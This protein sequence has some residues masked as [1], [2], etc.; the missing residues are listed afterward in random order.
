MAVGRK[1]TLGRQGGGDD[2]IRRVISRVTYIRR[3][4][5]GSDG[6]RRAAGGGVGVEEAVSAGSQVIVTKGGEVGDGSTD[7]IRKAL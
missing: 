6:E 7:R 5:G 3:S 4:S 2:I 1:T